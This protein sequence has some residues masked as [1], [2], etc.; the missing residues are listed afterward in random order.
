MVFGLFPG[1][2]SAPCGPLSFLFPSQADTRAGVSADACLAG[3]ASRRGRA[4]V[5][6]SWG[7]PSPACGRSDSVCAA[8]LSR[9]QLVSA[10]VLTSSQLPLSLLQKGEGVLVALVV[11]VR[12]PF[13]PSASPPFF[14]GARSDR[15]EK[16]RRER[17]RGKKGP[18]PGAGS[19]AEPQVSNTF[20]G[21]H[22]GKKKSRHKQP[23]GKQSQ[24]TTSVQV[25]QSAGESTQQPSRF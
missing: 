17:E 23:P 5:L 24:E 2:R 3:R 4:A 16:R 8:Q 9:P 14:F 6:E 25:A 18:P 19:G 1:R 15:G 7:V 11:S 21:E 10:P 12:P 20:R 13:L 22:G